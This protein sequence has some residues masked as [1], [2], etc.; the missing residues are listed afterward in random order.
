[1]NDMAETQLE[2]QVAANQASKMP[3]FNITIT[4]KR[5][6][7]VAYFND[8]YH[9]RALLFTLLRRDV[10]VRYH[11]TLIGFGWMVILP[12]SQILLYAFVFG[13]LAKLPSEGVPYV[14]FLIASLL[15]WQF[16]SRV[17]QESSQAVTSNGYLVTKIYFPRI[18]LIIS[19]V[20]SALLDLLIMLSI[21]II[22]LSLLGHP[23][24]WQIVA[25]PAFIALGTLFSFSVALLIAPVDVAY[26]DIRIVVGLV[27]QFLMFTSAVLY[28]TTVVPGGFEKLLGIA[29]LT[30][31]VTGFR[32]SILP[33]VSSPSLTGIAVC[34]VLSFA[35]LAIGVV[36]FAHHE[37]R[38]ADYI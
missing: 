28:P 23:P 33:G 5:R 35:F 18:I 17:I 14:F 36:R 7:N 3:A 16:L 20:F 38:F 12:A 13:A 37:D 8:I 9:H 27:L 2:A 31:L 22:T 21:G 6:L 25:L 11:Q 34:I 1:M 15:P 30:V 26:R 4:P 24:N 32:W 19:S 10:Q 29:P